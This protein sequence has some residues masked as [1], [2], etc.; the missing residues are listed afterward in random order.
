ML[1]GFAFQ[2]SVFVALAFVFAALFFGWQSITTKV[3]RGDADY[4][5]V[6]DC[7]DGFIVKKGRFPTSWKEM[8]EFASE[9]G[10]YSCIQGI[11]DRVAL[12]FSVFSVLNN[13][14]W[15]IEIIDDKDQ[16]VFYFQNRKP[17]SSE[18]DTLRKYCETLAAL[19]QERKK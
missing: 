14:A 1:K 13:N 12:N 9:S 18:Q 7:L 5:W 4:H 16:W 6:H 15:R 10:L 19:Q 3:F 17:P 8:H 11:E 2:I